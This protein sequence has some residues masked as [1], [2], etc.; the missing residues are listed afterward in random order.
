[1]LIHQ[2]N[3]LRRL[4]SYPGITKLKSESDRSNKRDFTI[5]D[6]IKTFKPSRTVNKIKI[7]KIKIIICCVAVRMFA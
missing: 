1:M 4:S 7:K 2:K 5:A 3:F 6:I